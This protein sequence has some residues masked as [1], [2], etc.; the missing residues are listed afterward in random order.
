MI[1]F[2][3]AGFISGAVGM[4]VYARWWMEKHIVYR[5]VLHEA[6]LEDEDGPCDCEGRDVPEQTG[7]VHKQDHMG[8][9]P[10]QC[11]ENKGQEKSGRGC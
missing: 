8:P 2:F 4:I 1:W 3:I 11:V 9:A 6:G 7:A 10:E 5:G